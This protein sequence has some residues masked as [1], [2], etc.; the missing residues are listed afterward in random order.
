MLA[1]GRWA[2]LDRLRGSADP[3]RLFQ[4]IPGIGP[5]LA[6][7]IHEG[8][9]IDTLE[10]LEVAAHDGRLES[11][12]GVGPRRTAQVRASLES[13]L[14]RRSRPGPPDP[15]PDEGVPEVETLLDVDREYRESAAAGRLPLIAPRRFNPER[16]AWLPVLHASRGRGHFTALFLQH[17]KIQDIGGARLAPGS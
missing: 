1:T 3:E 9:D 8:L 17:Q 16:K 4:R 12:P 7:R 5:R 10:E 13:L 14:S 2:Q 11:V 6:R 15:E